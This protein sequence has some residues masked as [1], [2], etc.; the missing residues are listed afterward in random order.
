[1]DFL[2]SILSP[3]AA[4]APGPADDYWYQPFAPLDGGV[5]PTPDQALTVSTIYRGV[6][7]LANTLAMLPLPVLERLP[8]ESGK[9]KAREHRLYR[10]LHDRPNRWQTSFQWRQMGMGHCVLRGNFFNRIVSDRR[11]FAA[12]LVPLDPT[13]TCVLDQLADGRLLYEYRAPSG[14]TERL[15]GGEDMFHIA[16]FGTSGR[17]GISVV[18]LMARTLEGA[19]NTESFGVRLF[20]HAPLMRGFLKHPRSLDPQARKNLEDSFAR[21]NAGP[22]GWHR[23]PVLENGLEWQAGGMMSAEDSQFLETRDFSIPEF[24]R[25]IGVPTVLLM[26]ADKTALYANAEQF[27]QSFLNFDIAHWFVNWET[28]INQTLFLDA[29]QDRFF[30]EFNRDAIVRGDIAA[31]GAF[32]QVMVNL[33]VFTRNEVRVLEG[34]NTLD[35]LDEPQANQAPRPGP[36]Q[37]VA[38][39]PQMHG[40]V[41]AAAGRLIRKE[42]AAVSKACERHP[43]DAAARAVEVARFYE[44][45]AI[46][47][48]ATLAVS[49]LVAA[50]YCTEQQAAVARDGLTAVQ[51]WSRPDHE[52]LVV[53][54]AAVGGVLR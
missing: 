42:C 15:V 39:P 19:I 11:G 1:M 24:A 17:A 48:A 30:C 37:G 40:I 18:Q 21:A 13:R 16:A 9:R 6:S 10:V 47:V 43:D 32:Y 44:R 54:L 53:S 22:T 41:V 49:S 34:K 5:S 3:R 33:G 52:V 29:E 50:A 26:H 14:G 4:I 12:E 31:R 46:E 27:F 25:F 35:G 2:T 45:F 51:A 7:V 8:D 28:A 20:S 36:P 38:P 23:A